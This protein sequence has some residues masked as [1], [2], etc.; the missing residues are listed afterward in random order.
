MPL[1][2]QIQQLKSTLLQHMPLSKKFN[3]HLDILIFMHQQT[4]HIFTNTTA[5]QEITQQLIGTH[6]TQE[7]T[8][9][10]SQEET[11]KS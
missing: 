7:Q 4:H 6:I 1:H 2:T 10:E 9:P 8:C 5:T 11:M 3:I